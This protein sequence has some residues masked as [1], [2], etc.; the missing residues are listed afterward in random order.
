MSHTVLRPLP[1]D[2]P[3]LSPDQMK[4]RR[5]SLGLAETDVADALLFS[6]AQV[7]AIEAGSPKP[8]YNDGF[9]AR[10]RTRYAS[11]LEA[12][13]LRKK[14]TANTVTQPSPEPP[15]LTLAAQAAALSAK[16]DAGDAAAQFALGLAY[17]VGRSG[18]TQDDA[19][20]VT[21]FRK[22]AEQGLP[23]AQ[24]NL[25]VAY[26]RGRGV[27]Q[28]GGQARAWLHKAAEQG[29]SKAQFNLGVLLANGR[30]GPRDYASAYAWVAVAVAQSSGETQ[31]RYARALVQIADRLDPQQLAEAER[32]ARE[33][34]ASI[35][36]RAKQVSGK[37]ER[38]S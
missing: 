24:F 34:H 14:P 21:W 37:T 6:V 18:V 26:D 7:R 5:E 27:S 4:A 15:A 33:K 30:G 32:T 20:A 3:T 9:Y 31:Q 36:M 29:L 10:A 13:D 25:G 23:K 16:A 35:Q 19:T 22:A 38:A 28:D 2:T 17:A 12:V 1:T 11:F 8:F